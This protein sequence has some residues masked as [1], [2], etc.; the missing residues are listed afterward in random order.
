MMASRDDDP[1]CETGSIKDVCEN[2]DEKPAE[3]KVSNKHVFIA[4][5]NNKQVWTVPKKVTL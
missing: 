5:L 2:G 3:D 4:P 1:C